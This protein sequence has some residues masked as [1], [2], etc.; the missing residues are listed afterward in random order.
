MTREVVQSDNATHRRIAMTDHCVALLQVA[1]F[2]IR[3]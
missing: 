2:L 3:Y 1:S